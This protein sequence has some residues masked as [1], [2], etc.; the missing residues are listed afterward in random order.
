MAN[1]RCTTAQTQE[2]LLAIET[3]STTLVTL[4][5]WIFLAKE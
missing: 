3:T 5:N 4:Y 2:T 1:A